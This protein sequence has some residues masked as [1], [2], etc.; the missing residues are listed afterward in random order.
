MMMEKTKEKEGLKTRKI[1]TLK[2]LANYNTTY[3][4]NHIYSFTAS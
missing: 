2:L 4:A 1:T 3:A